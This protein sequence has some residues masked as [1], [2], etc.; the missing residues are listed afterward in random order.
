[1]EETTFTVTAYK[2]GKEMFTLK[3]LSLPKAWETIARGFVNSADRVV[4]DKVNPHSPPWV[5][6]W[7]KETGLW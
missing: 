5:T 2:K 1:M 3:R 4:V 6:E 7:E